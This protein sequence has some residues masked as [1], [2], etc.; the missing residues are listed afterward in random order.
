MT[1]NKIIFKKEP[2]W[3]FKV[4]GMLQQNMHLSMRNHTRKF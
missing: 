1:P 2:E 4:I 3:Y